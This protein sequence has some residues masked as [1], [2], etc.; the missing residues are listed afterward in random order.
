MRERERG[1]RKE[2]QSKQ[3]S[4]LAATL[5]VH[6]HSHSSPLLACALCRSSDSCVLL[7]IALGPGDGHLVL[8]A[9]HNRISGPTYLFRRWKKI[10]QSS[11]V[12]P[13]YFPKTVH[14]EA[15][16]EREIWSRLPFSH[17]FIFPLSDTIFLLSE[18]SHPFATPKQLLIALFSCCQPVTPCTHQWLMHTEIAEKWGD[19]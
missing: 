1:A 13:L 9:L 18:I 5:A 2:W 15:V 4:P 19:S 11:F 17:L 16:A 7:F 8:C 10:V 12:W 3:A 14:F 6:S